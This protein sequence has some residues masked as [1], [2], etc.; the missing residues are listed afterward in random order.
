MTTINIP[1]S[2]AFFAGLASFLSPCVFSLV[3]AYIGYLSG[4]T[5]NQDSSVTYKQ[6]LA[7]TF[8]HGLAFVV[9][10]STV[11]VIFG[12]AFSAIGRL[13][14]N[15]AP[16]LAKVGGVIIIFFGLH[17]S[18]FLKLPFLYFDLRIHSNK[19]QQRTL[20]TSFLTGIFFSAGWSPC[21]GPTLGLILTL[22]TASQSI[23]QGAILLAIYS[24]GMGLPFLLA[25][26]GL[27]WI[28]KTLQKYAKMLHYL[29]LIVGYIM[30]IIGAL[31][32][33]GI[34]QKLVNFGPI[35]DY[36]I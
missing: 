36:G 13:F 24:I 7:Y 4:R 21:I 10:F 17:M 5:L 6:S 26:I 3:P 31:L 29:E 14:S 22:S 30:I 23:R 27:G 33:L 1:F 28:T 8:F 32:F 12:I 18:G 19:L 25:A 9:G 20:L 15:I 35:I 11:F 2:L 16:L 34:Y